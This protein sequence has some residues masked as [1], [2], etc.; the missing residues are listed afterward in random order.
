MPLRALE[1]TNWAILYIK[2]TGSGESRGS[3]FVEMP[4]KAEAKSAMRGLRS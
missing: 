4:A 2:D 1:R 3:G